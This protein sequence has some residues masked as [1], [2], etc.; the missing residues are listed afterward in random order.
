[1]SLPSSPAANAHAA[2]DGFA[3]E[4]RVVVVSALHLGFL[5][6]AFGAMSLPAQS[7]S[8]ILAA[9]AFVCAVLPDRSP[10]VAGVETPGRRLIAS[11]LFWLGAAVLL[12]VAIQGLNPAWRV[13][14]DA[15]AWWLEP[16]EAIR[17][18]P[19]GIAAPPEPANAWT[20]LLVFGSAWLQA[21]ALAVGVSRRGALLTLLA[22][23]AANGALVATLGALQALSGTDR[24]YWRHLPS[25]SSFISSFVYRNHGGAYLNLMVAVAAGLAWHGLR[26]VRVSR[27]AIAGVAAATLAAGLGAAVVV[28][29]ASRASIVMTLGFFACLALAAL[30][31]R[32]RYGRVPRSNLALVALAAAGLVGVGG[33]TY[34]LEDVRS[35][36]VDLTSDLERA[37]RDRR[38]AHAAAFALVREGWPAGWGAGGF[39]HAFPLTLAEHP[40][41]H[42]EGA[43]RRVWEHA[44]HDPL[45]FAV[46]LGLWGLAPLAAAL[47]LLAGKLW[48]GRVWTCPLALPLVLAVGFLG[49]HSTVD[50]VL[51]CPAI[52]I[53]ALALMT[54]AVRWLHS[55][56]T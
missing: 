52:L 8:G 55:E 43:G 33:L 5:P 51:Q 9:V 11:P 31:E 49:L 15:E 40:R 10:P 19:H 56:S 48:R 3:R 17:W 26:R 45:Q 2:G 29:S 50:F 35:R 44:H 36:F 38:E 24:I 1:V 23:L 42:G 28:L 47:T 7:V 22:I 4:R 12:V 30:L 21:S 37:S 27:A 46:E 32:F 13:V 20:T 54:V 14:G 39:R 6:W 41:V 18:L 34:G 16:V 53:T 25:N